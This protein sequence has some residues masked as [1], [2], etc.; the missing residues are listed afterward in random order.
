MNNLVRILLGLCLLVSLPGLSV[1]DATGIGSGEPLQLTDIHGND[2]TAHRWRWL[3]QQGLETASGHSILVDE[4]LGG[5]AYATSGPDGGLRSSGALVGAVPPEALELPLHLRPAA[6]NEDAQRHLHAEQDASLIPQDEPQPQAPDCLGTPGRFMG[7]VTDE[8]GAPIANAQVWAGR[9]AGTSRG[10]DSSPHWASEGWTMMTGANGEYSLEV[11]PGFYELWAGA[12]GYANT[13]FP[14]ELTVTAAGEAPTSV[15]L[16][17]AAAAQ[18]SGQLSNAS[19]QPLEGE[20]DLYRQNLETGYWDRLRT[21]SATGGAFLFDSLAPGSYTLGFRADGYLPEYYN[22]ASDLEAATPIPLVAGQTEA[23]I[24][25]ALAPAGS[26][27]GAVYKADGSPVDEYLQVKLYDPSGE[28]FGPYDSV[29]STNARPWDEGRFEFSAVRPGSY[30]LWFDGDEQYTS[31]WYDDQLL[32]ENATPVVVTAGQQ[33]GPI[34]AR[35]DAIA[36]T[37]GTMSG[38]VTD[39]EGNPLSGIDIIAFNQPDSSS[40]WRW[41]YGPRTNTDGTYV[42]A[43]LESGTYRMQFYGGFDYSSEWYEGV[44]DRDAATDILISEEVTTT[45]ID[46]QLHRWNASVTGQVADHATGIPA[47]RVAVFLQYDP[48]QTILTGRSTDVCG[49]YRNPIDAGLPF[50]IYFSP[51][52]D[53]HWPQRW[54]YENARNYEQA[55]LLTVPMGQ[56]SFTQDVS[57]PRPGSISGSITDSLGD[58]LEGYHVEAFYPCETSWCGGWPHYLYTDADGG[59]NL[60][61]LLPDRYRIGVRDSDHDWWF[62]GGVDAVENATDI[63]VAAGQERTGIDIALNQQSETHALTVSVSGPGSVSSNP[64]GID[65]G[66]DCSEDFTA[67]TAVTLTATPGVDA[68]FDAWGG[69]CGG[70]NQDCTVTLDQPRS[71][72]ASFSNAGGDRCDPGPL[73]VTE[74]VISG[75]RLYQSETT[76]A[77]S[78][79]VQISAGADVGFEASDTI[80][81]NPGFAVAATARFIARL[82]PVVCP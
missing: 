42:M 27:V 50:A 1:A 81:L 77:T 80:T 49:M 20:V 51:W 72:F 6:D 31:E 78:G 19:S 55:T 64:A 15:D 53:P 21:A 68:L 41:H 45:G 26:I 17:L 10:Y 82:T 8:G 37:G 59:Y 75:Q 29:A 12:P 25:A 39:E 76:L 79:P 74:P 60:T 35:L 47:E 18:I 70:S 58:P 73:W 7:M 23:G 52:D 4:Q 44:Q 63:L 62:Y 9:W 54:W 61:G 43:G 5:W 11:P 69:A 34:D 65:C 33:A 71:V 57:L 28:D 40:Y 38:L 56:Q 16:R 67:G 14:Q 24:S 66:N 2:F 22:D 36:P 3:D 13:A 30:Y 46:A 32:V 48:N